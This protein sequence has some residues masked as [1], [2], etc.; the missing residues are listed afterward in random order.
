MSPQNGYKETKMLNGNEIL[1]PGQKVLITRTATFEYEVDIADYLEDD[2]DKE[3]SVD[4]LKEC[5]LEN[6]GISEIEGT[7]D[8]Y[9][10]VDEEVTSV[11]L[12]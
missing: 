12:I 6:M 3:I 9:D 7:Y 11:T 2:D 4:Q 1:R 10:I 8:N 5:E